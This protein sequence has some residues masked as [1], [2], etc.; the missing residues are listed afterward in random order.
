ME[1]ACRDPDGTVEVRLALPIRRAKSSRVDRVGAGWPKRVSTSVTFSLPRPQRTTAAGVFG[2]G[3]RRHFDALGPVTQP[4]YVG[5]RPLPDGDTA[6]TV[7]DG[8]QDGVPGVGQK[9]VERTAARAGR[10]C[11]LPQSGTV[12]G[13]SAV[14]PGPRRDG[15]RAVAAARRGLPGTG[16]GN[17]GLVHTGMPGHPSAAQRWVPST[18]GKPLQEVRPTAHSLFSFAASRPSTNV[19]T[20]SMSPIREG[21]ICRGSSPRTTRSARFPGVRLP[22]LSSHRQA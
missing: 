21:S 22:A 15:R 11:G 13:R 3:Q 5:V 18:V 4:H 14:P 8:H 1:V 7:R 12:R 2:G 20:T 9:E 6:R 10:P 17:D 19:A 16:R